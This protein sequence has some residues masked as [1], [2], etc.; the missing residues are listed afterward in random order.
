MP[1]APVG[2]PPLEPKFGCWNETDVTP[3]HLAV[4]S[5]DKHQWGKGCVVE[6]LM[7]HAA[8]LNVESTV[9]VASQKEID[10]AQA[11]PEGDDR[12]NRR[13]RQQLPLWLRSPN[14][15][16]E[17]GVKRS[18]QR[19]GT[20]LQGYQAAVDLLQQPK[21]PMSSWA[22][23]LRT[24]PCVCLYFGVFLKALIAQASI[25]IGQAEVQINVGDLFNKF[26][27]QCVVE[28]RGL[29]Y[30]VKPDQDCSSDTVAAEGQQRVKDVFRQ[31]AERMQTAAERPRR[32]T[33]I[34]DFRAAR[35]NPSRC[36]AEAEDSGIPDS[37]RIRRERLN[38]ISEAGGSKDLKNDL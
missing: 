24:I 22:C 21:A 25:D 11:N 35:P 31:A 1:Q 30:L 34:C 19:A 9:V 12:P 7:Y 27:L 38:P 5:E 26:V 37:D 20:L 29:Q 18:C 4:T 23:G 32:F 16:A 17:I 13:M 10:F 2:G 15:L 6:L 28:A 8:S 14:H 33:T 3:L 36:P